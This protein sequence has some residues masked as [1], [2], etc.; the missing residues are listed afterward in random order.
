[1]NE[2]SFSDL[3]REELTDEE[4]WKWARTWL[5]GSFIAGIAED[6]GSEFAKSETKHLKRMF[7]RLKVVL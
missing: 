5:D 3:I 6:Y 2:M 1:M 4:F 7:P